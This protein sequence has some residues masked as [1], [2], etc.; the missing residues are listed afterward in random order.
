MRSGDIG[1]V[2]ELA[3]SLSDAPSWPAGVYLAALDPN[4]LPKRIVLVAETGDSAVL[5]GFAVASMVPPQAELESIAVRADQ[6][7]QGIGRML[8]NELVNELAAAA[9]SEML[10]EVRASNDVARDFYASSGWRQTGSRA[11]YYSNP[12]DDAILMSLDLESRD[13]AI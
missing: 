6:Q 3:A 9:V 11:R 12:E 13:R 8:L 4:R 2:S 7:R 5:S 10:L 1:A